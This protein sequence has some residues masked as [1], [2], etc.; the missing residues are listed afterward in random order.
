MHIVII[1]INIGGYHAARLKS[2]FQMC[3][4]LDW[5]FTAIQVTDDT[6]EHSWGDFVSSL[7]VPVETLLTTKSGNNTKQD[8][9]STVACQSLK[10]CLARIKPDIVFIPGWYFAIAK[11][12]LRWCRQNKVIPLLMSESNEHDAPRV[13]WKEL[14]KTW[15]VGKYKAALVGG[16][17]HQEYLSNLGMNSEA[18]FLGYDVVDNDFFAPHNLKNQLQPNQKHYFLSVG[19]FIHKKNFLLL[20]KAY[21]HYLEKSGT[22]SWDLILCGSG[23]L[24]SL[25]EKNINELNLQNRVHLPGF[26]KPKELLPY[27]AHAGCFVHASTTEQWGLVVNEAMAA[28]LPVLVSNRCGCFEDL[29]IEGVNGFGFDPYDFQQLSKLMLTIS[30]NSFNRQKMG[31][32]ALK[33]IQNFAPDRFA[34]GLVQAVEYAITH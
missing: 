25:I 10:S 27:F 12:A 13:W 20:L 21:A 23:Q 18:V 9:F 5:K 17:K 6:L 19:R 33:H 31:R 11:T 4:K 14:Y 16:S 32:A 15:I 22:N 1:F 34:N 26:L 28:G 3:Q 8:A 29:I 30:A 2:T 7:G 24:Q